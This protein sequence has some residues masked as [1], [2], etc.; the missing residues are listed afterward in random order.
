MGESNN[1]KTVS[2]LIR[3]SPHIITRASGN[4]IDQ[5]L[6]VKNCLLPSDTV[7]AEAVY[8]VAYRKRALI[9]PLARGSRLLIIIRGPRMGER[10]ERSTVFARSRFCASA[11]ARSPS[12]ELINYFP[13]ISFSLSEPEREPARGD[14]CCD[15]TELHLRAAAALRSEPSSCRSRLLT[16][17]FRA[18]PC[19][20]L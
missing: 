3:R 16:R 15:F 2:R 14:K 5:F 10:A 18:A 17:R 20:Y 1:W 19:T 4:L 12:A 7:R 6:T 8:F 13:P 9:P 11:H